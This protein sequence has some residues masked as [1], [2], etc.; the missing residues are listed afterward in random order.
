LTTTKDHRC[1]REGFPTTVKLRLLVAFSA[2][3][4]LYDLV[5]RMDAGLADG[6]C[7]GDRAT[8][9]SGAAACRR[10]ERGSNSL[11]RFLHANRYQ[12]RWKTL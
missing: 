1:P 12:L 7:N 4:A 10:S 6:G 2:L 5:R 9:N 11:T 3:A 8:I